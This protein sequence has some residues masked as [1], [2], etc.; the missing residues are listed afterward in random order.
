MALSL[1]QI[2][3]FLL[4]ILCFDRVFGVGAIDDAGTWNVLWWN[5]ESRQCLE[6][7]DK[8]CGIFALI[9]IQWVILGYTL[10]F[11][12]DIGQLIGN[13]NHLFWAISKILRLV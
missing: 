13:L 4:W 12:D 3:K 5:G 9:C 1:V 7:N 11:G 8:L 6:H 10:A 2:P